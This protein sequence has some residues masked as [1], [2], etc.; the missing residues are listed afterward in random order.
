MSTIHKIRPSIFGWAAFIFAELL[1]IFLVGHIGVTFLR[2][3]SEKLI[4]MIEF[5]KR[6]ASEKDR[7]FIF[8]LLRS[9]LSSYGLHE[10]PIDRFQVTGSGGSKKLRYRKIEEVEIESVYVVLNES[11]L[12]GAYK[13]DDL[14]G[15]IS[16]RISWLASTEIFR[17]VGCYVVN[18]VK[19]HAEERG[20]STIILSVNKHNNRAIKCYKNGGFIKNTEAENTSEEFKMKFTVTSG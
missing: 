3:L 10:T 9:K 16:C 19:E 14:S 1:I 11:E 8:Q 2:V 18:K 17:G 5:A 4:T 7:L 6:Q 13:L 12:V 20:F 15:G